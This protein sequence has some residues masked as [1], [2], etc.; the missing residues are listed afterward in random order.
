MLQRHDPPAQPEEFTVSEPVGQGEFQRAFETLS[1]QLGEVAATSRE[2]LA[3]ARKANER[4]IGLEHRASAFE[5]RLEA[6]E[7]HTPRPP[8]A[9][10]TH[11][12]P[13]DDS[14]PVTRW[15]LGA[16]VTV[17]LAVISVLRFFG[18]V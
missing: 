11:V 9:P 3:E 1:R 13:A 6:L 7:R 4:S 5:R 10:P 17:I 16:A 15:D 8:A 18:K 2:T 12:A 14:K